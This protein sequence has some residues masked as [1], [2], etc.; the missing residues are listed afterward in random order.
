MD[1]CCI[2]GTFDGVN[3]TSEIIALQSTKYGKVCPKC[4][5]RLVASHFTI[6]DMVSD[7]LSI[8]NGLPLRTID[9]NNLKGVLAKY[10]AKYLYVYGERHNGV[11]ENE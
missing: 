5:T 4:I 10:K 6:K 9:D 3:K 8:I 1:A 7:L 11:E 2:C